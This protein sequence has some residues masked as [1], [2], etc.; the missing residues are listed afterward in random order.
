VLIHAGLYTLYFLIS[1]F[2]TILKTVFG[3]LEMFNRVDT[4][5]VGFSAV[6]LF[7]W[8]FLL[9]PKGEEVKMSIPHFSADEEERILYKLDALNAT[10]LKVGGK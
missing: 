3:S 1:T 5:L 6:C 9:S 10:L 4:Y 7:A 2:T 8:Y